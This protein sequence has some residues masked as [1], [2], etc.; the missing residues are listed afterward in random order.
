M[1]KAESR[2]AKRFVAFPSWALIVLV[3]AFMAATACSSNSTVTLADGTEADPTAT[4]AEDD[5]TPEPSATDVPADDSDDS[6]EEVEPTVPPTAEP[7]TEP[8]PS[9]AA[10]DTDDGAAF[11]GADSGDFCRI[12]RELDEDNPFEDPELAPFTEE[13]FEATLDFYEQVE[14]IAPAEIR[15]DFVAIRG[16]LEQLADTAARFDYN[17][18]DPALAQ[19]IETID[20]AELDEAGENIEN[21]LLDVCGLDISS[22]DSMDSTSGADMPEDMAEML[23]GLDLENLSDADVAA[24]SQLL[25]SQLADPELQACLLENIDALLAAAEDPNALNQEICGTTLFSIFAGLGG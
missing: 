9:A 16:G 7:T 13:W 2:R 17:L 5:G 6:D 23:G 18:F 19:A 10:D 24:L 15:G 22:L 20:T 21:Y 8:A 3:A 14:A 4:P 11:S 12:A 25:F 1:T